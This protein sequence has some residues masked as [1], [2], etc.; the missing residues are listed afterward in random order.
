MVTQAEIRNGIDVAEVLE[1]I[2]IMRTTPEA[3]A[4]R[5]TTRHLWRSGYA[6]DGM[7]DHLEVGGES[8]VRTRVVRSDIPTE[9]GGEDSGP[10]PGELLLFALG[11]CITGTY[12]EQAALAGVVVDEIETTIVASADLRGAYNV[13]QVP[14]GLGAVTATIRVK[15]GADKSLHDDIARLAIQRSPVAR[16]LNDRVPISVTTYTGLLPG[17]T[18]DLIVPMLPD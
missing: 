10:A 1:W 13:S 15:S 6:V 3:A 14:V 5:L 2:D 18:S 7:V 17:R 9:L 16:S 4:V 12:A 11:A 8:I